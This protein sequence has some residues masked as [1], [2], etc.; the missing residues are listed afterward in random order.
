MTS[1]KRSLVKDSVQRI[2]SKQEIFLLLGDSWNHGCQG[3]DQRIDELPDS[4]GPF[5]SVRANGV[6][7]IPY[8]DEDI[9]IW[10]KMDYP[11]LNIGFAEPSLRGATCFY[12]VTAFVTHCLFFT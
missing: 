9:V 8:N 6:L 11:Y 10:G 3:P 4:L 1:C 12:P 2:H 7:R 5:T